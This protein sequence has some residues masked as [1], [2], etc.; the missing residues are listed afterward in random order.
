MEE[1]I[2][3]SELISQL[4]ILHNIANKMNFWSQGHRIALDKIGELLNSIVLEKSKKYLIMLDLNGILIDRKYGKELK[5]NNKCSKVGNFLVW[6][7]PFLDEFIDFL[8][9]HYDVA[10]WSSVKL[11][12][13]QQ[14]V[15]FIF[16]DKERKL[17]LIWSQD[18]CEAVENPNINSKKPLFLKNLSYLWEMFPQ[19]DQ[20]NTLLID[21]SDDKSKNNDPQN[22]YNPGTWTHDMKDESLAVGGDIRE[23][24]KS[25]TKGTLPK[26]VSHLLE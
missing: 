11:W 20:T 19:Y 21:D 2:E 10:I 7:R 6:K 4:K 3:K 26:E 23:T 15:A 16:G 9:E 1:V 5:A 12:N 13:I 18:Q 8:F 14:L 22:H 17:K 25:F 24:I